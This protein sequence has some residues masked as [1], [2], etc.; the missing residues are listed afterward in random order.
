M[1]K[2]EKD[3]KKTIIYKEIIDKIKPE[4]DYDPPSTL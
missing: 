3:N 2:K 4:L 1:I